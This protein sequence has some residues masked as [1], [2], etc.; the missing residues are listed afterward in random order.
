MPEILY[1]SCGGF[2]AW[3]LPTVPLHP[4]TK[5]TA[6]IPNDTS[7]KFLPGFEKSAF[8]GFEWLVLLFDLN[9][10]PYTTLLPPRAVYK[11]APDQSTGLRC[12]YGTGGT[13]E[14]KDKVKSLNA[15]ISYRLTNP[16]VAVT[17]RSVQIRQ[18][19]CLFRPIARLS[20]SQ[21]RKIR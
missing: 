8:V 3:V 12:K 20:P 21:I 16:A 11:H 15:E 5:T 13:T 1:V 4:L 17:Y 14:R 18:T 7:A 2:V 9:T 6:S 10:I 19:I